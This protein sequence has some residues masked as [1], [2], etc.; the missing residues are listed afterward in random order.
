[1]KEKELK[2]LISY[3]MERSREA[4]RAA[5]IMFDNGMLISAMNRQICLS[6]RLMI[7]SKLKIN[8]YEPM[9]LTAHRSLERQ[10]GYIP[11]RVS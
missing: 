7:I 8:D 2:D 1:M 9:N 5:Q 4:C 6:P 10:S 3:R 11:Y